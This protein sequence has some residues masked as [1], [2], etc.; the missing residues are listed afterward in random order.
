ML[1]KEMKIK[2]NKQKISRLQMCNTT[3]PLYMIKCIEMLTHVQKK[4]KKKTDVELS[5]NFKWLR[6]KL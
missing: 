6:R 2:Q 3:T 1:Y 4:N 5:L